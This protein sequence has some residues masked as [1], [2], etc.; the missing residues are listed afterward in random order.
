MRSGSVPDINLTY[1]TFKDHCGA[2]GVWLVK[3]WVKSISALD[4]YIVVWLM[5]VKV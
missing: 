3:A 2:E 5:P 1:G 4:T